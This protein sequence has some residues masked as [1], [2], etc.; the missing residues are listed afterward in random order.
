MIRFRPARMR[1]YRKA[2][3]R[4]LLGGNHID[5]ARL[6]AVCDTVRARADAIASK[7][8]VPAHV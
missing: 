6:V 4:T 1:A 8:G 5:G 3:L 2:P 7:F